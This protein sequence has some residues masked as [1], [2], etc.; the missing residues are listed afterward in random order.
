MLDNP[1]K[2]K[3]SYLDLRARLRELDIKIMDLAQMLQI[4]RPTLYK[5]IECFNS[6]D[7]SKI[8]PHILSL[9]NYLQ[10]RYI[11]KNNVFIYI[12]EN[13]LK[14]NARE[15][16]RG[17]FTEMI[18]HT[19]AFNEILE[20]LIACNTLLQKE[21]KSPKELAFLAPLETFIHNIHTLKEKI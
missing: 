21:T 7:T 1:L 20:Y 18:S 5:M 13:I 6:K 15:D 10:N 4:S 2:P 11:N 14:S 16:V 17:R 12:T 19:T 3:E 8:P 9:F